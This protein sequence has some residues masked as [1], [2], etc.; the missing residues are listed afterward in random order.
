LV[1]GTL[2][3]S[4]INS[5]A[6][7]AGKS[8]ASGTFEVTKTLWP[9]VAKAAKIDP[10]SVK[11]VTVDPNL[12]INMVLKGDAQAAGGFYSVL[13]DWNERGI[14]ADEI[15]L[16]KVSDIGVRFYG[17]A[18][19][20]ST[21]LITENPKA[22]SAFLRAYNRAF[23]EGLANPPASV[24]FLK[25]REPLI[26]EALETRRFTLLIPA[27]ITEST[28]ANGLGEVDRAVLTKQVDEISAAFKLKTKPSVEQLF[29]SEFLPPR[30]E[31][32]PP[33]MPR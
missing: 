16:H 29:A 1:Y 27:M 33:A 7:L 6:E 8:I 18:V 14:S 4:G 12:R 21:R 5:I 20:A 24:K 23:K 31:R 2:K 13:I 3:K 10:G 9:I 22:V 28:R 26:D 25:Q 17:N 30:T 19:L 11:W 32:M 15:T